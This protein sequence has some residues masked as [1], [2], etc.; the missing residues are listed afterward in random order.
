MIF[1]WF[2]SEEAGGYGARY[3][4][5]RPPVPLDHDRRQPGVRDDR[6][7]GQRGR[8]RTRSGSPATSAP[9]SVR[10]WRGTER[11]IVEDPHPE[12]NFFQRSDNIV[13]ARQGVVA[14]TVSSYGLHTEYHQPSDDLA[15]LDVAHMTESIPSMLEPVRWLANSTF[16]PAW[17]PGMKP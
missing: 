8:R 7:P 5:E 9:I 3:F 10:S 13:L 14:Q 4:V 15:H 1:A 16:K 2:G 6:P 12:Q 11:G 17:L